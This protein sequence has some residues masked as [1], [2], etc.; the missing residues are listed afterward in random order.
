M[1][2]GSF[3]VHIREQG[4]PRPKRRGACRAHQLRRERG[5]HDPVLVAATLD[6]APGGVEQGLRVVCVGLE[7]DQCE[8][9]AVDEGQR[10][11]QGRDAF[12]RA[13]VANRVNSRYQ[14]SMGRRWRRR[15]LR[16]SWTRMPRRSARS[17][18]AFDAPAP[19]LSVPP[20]CL[21]V[22]VRIPPV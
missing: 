4:E 11:G 3:T 21:P 19:A 22:S 14:A 8:R 2:A 7:L 20:V 13:T 17:S 9:A 1:R 15:S 10:L 18:G 6:L 5:E 12:V 16:M